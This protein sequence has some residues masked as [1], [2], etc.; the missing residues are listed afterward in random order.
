MSLSLVHPDDINTHWVIAKRFLDKC[1]SDKLDAD[2]FLPALLT[3]NAQ[4]W[5]I[6]DESKTIKA[7]GISRISNFPKC[8]VLQLVALA[9]DDMR[10]WMHHIDD[11]I[12]FARKYG[13]AK[14]EAT[15]RPGWER[16]FPAF[17]RARVRLDMTI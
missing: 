16:L 17:K 2:D 1:D 12:D 3:G 8:R 13:C 10:D 5:L 15:G 9:G 6:D 14:I 11:M 7:A 4:L